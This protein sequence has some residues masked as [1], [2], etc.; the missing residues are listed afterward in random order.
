MGWKLLKEHFRIGHN[1]QV[2]D[3]GVCIGSP[4]IPN[5]IVIAAD[6]KCV[7]RYDMSRRSFTNENLCRYQRE[8]DWDPELVRRILET[9]D[10]FERSLT[11]WTYDD[12][13][14]IEKHCEE[15]GYPNPCH[16]GTMQYDNTHSPDKEKVVAWAKRDLQIGLKWNAENIAEAQQKLDK[17]RQYRETLQDRN[18]RL[19]REYP[20]IEPAPRH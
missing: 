2:T 16:D 4:Y 7:K 19:G 14:V 13:E 3:K 1:V 15:Y 18:E 17:L 5:I 12:G 11:V 6:G 20:D 10:T 8:L 9:P